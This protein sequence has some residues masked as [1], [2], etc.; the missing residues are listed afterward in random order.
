MAVFVWVI[1]TLV[2]LPLLSWYVCFW[3]YIKR[4]KNKKNAI[5]FASDWSTV[6]FIAS[7]HFILL[8]IFGRSFLFIVLGVVVLIAIGFTWLHWYVSEDIH[9]RKLIRGI[10]RL[11]FIVFFLLHV[12]LFFVGL[13]VSIIRLNS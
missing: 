9:I 10:W 3:I 12:S 8:E 13:F 5:R 4:K 7:V 11:N 1:A 6:L 2:T